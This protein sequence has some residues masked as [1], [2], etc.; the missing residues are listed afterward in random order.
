MDLSVKLSKK[1]LLNLCYKLRKVFYLIYLSETSCN[2]TTSSYNNTMPRGWCE[3]HLLAG[4]WMLFSTTICC[5]S[6]I[7]VESCINSVAPAK[8]WLSQVEYW[9]RAVVKYGATSEV[10][11]WAHFA[12]LHTNHSKRLELSSKYNI[13]T[14]NAYAAISAFRLITGLCL[15]WVV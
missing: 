13:S 10:T 2:E 3:R 11:M 9:I 15:E 7:G 14:K 6:G 1:R 5:L 12:R 8:N 4:R